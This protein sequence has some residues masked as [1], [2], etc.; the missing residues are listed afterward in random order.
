MVA[1]LNNF[2][3]KA[4]GENTDLASQLENA[5]SKINSLTKAKNDL[6]AQLE[7]SKQEMA[8]ETK[9]CLKCTG[10]WFNS[11]AFF[12]GKTGCYFQVEANRSGAG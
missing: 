12:L 2:K 3:N 5:E 7:E 8:M 9:V 10:A 1:D 4:Q 6:Q 11:V